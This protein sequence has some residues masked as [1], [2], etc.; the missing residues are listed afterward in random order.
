[1]V[2]LI[3][4]GCNGYMGR[5]ITQCVKERCDCEI[6]AG[7][8]INTESHA[9]FPVYANPA[10]CQME[11]DA[12]IDFSHP[13]A[14]AGV[15]AY[16]KAHRLP[17]VIATTGL[18]AEQIVE[19]H[20]AADTVPMFFTANMSLGINL[21]SELIQKAAT[22]L[23]NDFDVEIVEKHH[24]RKVDAPSGTALML[25]DAVSAALP[26][27]PEYVYDRHSV[28]RPR[29]KKEIGISA[30]RGGTIVGEHDVIFAG[31]D[32]IITLSHTA[33]SKE[34]FAVGAINAALFMVGKS[35]GHYTMKDLI[36]A[37]N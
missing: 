9:G 13:S 37:T 8:D 15:L 12:I 28:R 36:G 29:D 20:A 14:L 31:R 27:E 17:T 18:S 24:N 30:I 26:Y 25:A 35:A 3:V 33:M 4:S 23:G 11:A 22:I 10:N 16:A 32:E 19:V 21:L 34:V 5:V 6:V 2:R 1:M 7:F